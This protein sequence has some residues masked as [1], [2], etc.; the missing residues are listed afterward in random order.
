MC[1]FELKNLDLGRPVVAAD[2]VDRDVFPLRPDDEGVHCYLCQQE[3][4]GTEHL[5]PL[6]VSTGV[7]T[8]KVKCDMDS[9]VWV[10]LEHIPFCSKEFEAFTPEVQQQLHN[11]R[12]LRD[13]DRLMN[14]DMKE[15]AAM[16][17]LLRERRFGSRRNKLA[18]KKWLA[19]SLS[20]ED[21]LVMFKASISD[22]SR[23]GLGVDHGG[24]PA[25][26]E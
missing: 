18:A 26:V 14:P 22:Y 21:S 8:L 19:S 16:K 10:C 7:F 5:E 12:Y 3:S 15:H 6:T 20:P 11:I 2:I 17:I 24:L 9:P 13:S 23:C 25:S 4:H 1:C